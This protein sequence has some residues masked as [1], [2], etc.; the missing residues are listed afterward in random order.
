M[1]PAK[2]SISKNHGRKRRSG[3][4]L[5]APRM[6][7]SIITHSLV[8]M[9]CLYIGFMVG[10]GRQIAMSVED[11]V[12]P[13]KLQLRNQQ[14]RLTK[15]LNGTN[16]LPS[17]TAIDSELKNDRGQQA[18]HPQQR[19]TPFPRTSRNI[20][21]DFAT[22]PRDAFNELIDIGVP[23]DDT[24]KG[25]EDVLV[26]YTSGAG[27]P[28]GMG[29][30][31]NKTGID[32]TKALENCHEVKVVLQ[33]TTNKNHDQCFAIV[34]QWQSYMVHKWMRVP[35]QG[36]PKNVT[37]VDLTFPLQSV[38]RIR[39][40][41]D[42]GQF[43]GV[44]REKPIAESNELLV[45]YLQNRDR[46]LVDLKNFLKYNVMKHAKDP[47]LKA[48]V[49]LTCNKGQSEMFR[50]F[51]CNARAK[52]LDL[53]HVV[54]FATDEATVQLSRELGIHVWYD[55][56]I[57]GSIPEESAL[58]YGDPIF[59][60]M[61]MAKVYCMHLAMSSGYDIL[62]Q[63]VDVVWHRNPLPFLVSEQFEG[64]DMVFQDDGS[65]VWRYAPYSP[66]SGFYFVRN[67]P[68][69]TFLFETFL[70]MGDMI[71][72]AKSHQHV[73]NDLLIEF[74]STKGLKVKVLRKG[75]DN[76]FPGGVEFHNKAKFMKEMI[77]G[78]RKPYVFHMSWTNN[79]ENKQKFFEQLGEWYVGDNDASYAGCSGT[80]CCLT[81]P[82]IKCHYRD[83][84]SK[85][86][87]LDSPRIDGNQMENVSFW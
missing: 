18:E 50:N 6:I 40:P 52:E 73:M 22:V 83:K 64:W 69:T 34:P 55:A 77:Q 28:T 76:V 65:R 45:E 72:V 19:V 61:M 63:D 24:T 30:R 36:S 70:K 7:Q 8:G 62:F 79:K 17:V 2:N 49:I 25:A 84:P 78:T 27:M 85:I 60:K 10:M 48:L 47:S 46:V 54:M 81:Q 86:P 9:V 59:S 5:L 29:W 80:E 4:N 26:L 31:H 75:D 66:N 43:T 56:A 68:V 87:C 71:Q 53:S 15:E 82:N 21:V 35:P 16:C 33:E 12:G 41:D 67:N 1:N 38:P 39:Q 42:G 14:Y 32:P 57:F 13:S 20:F 74:S 3:G 37:A 11:A 23:L 44:P 58:K 51:V